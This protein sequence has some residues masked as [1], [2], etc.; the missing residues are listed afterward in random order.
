MRQVET[1]NRNIP[2]H[3]CSSSVRLFTSSSS[4]YYANEPLGQEQIEKKLEE[5]LEKQKQLRD[6]FVQ[7]EQIDATPKEKEEEKKIQGR[8]AKIWAKIKHEV[9][10]YVTGAKLLAANVGI[11]KDLIKK[12]LHGGS[13]TRREK[14]LLRRTTLDIFRVFPFML[15]FII[16]FLEFA[17]P[18]F[19]KMFPQMLPSTFETSLQRE[20]NMKRQLK[21]KLE[22]AKF[23]Q[24]SVHSF[25]PQVNSDEKS[26][27][28]KS[29]DDA[30]QVQQ[31]LA[32]VHSGEELL[33]NEILQLSSLF[34]DEFTLDNLERDQLKAVCKFLNV[35]SFGTTG[36]L[37]Y[38]LRTRFNE[39]KEDD[40]LIDNEG[41]DAL[42][43]EELQAACQ[44]RGMR[45]I[46]VSA[47]VLRRQLQQWLDLSLREKLPTS[48]L[49]L[50][51]ALNITADP[52]QVRPVSTKDSTIADL[53]KLLTALPADV[54]D[55]ALVDYAGDSDQSSEAKLAFL[56]RAREQLQDSDSEDKA[57]AVAAGVID[58]GQREQVL[59][60]L[61]A[62]LSTMA[63]RSAVDLERAELE[64]LKIE[65]DSAPDS[66]FQHTL[67]GWLDNIEDQL[68]KVD[69]SI[70]ENLHLL[71]RDGD[72]I[73][74]QGELTIGLKY[75]KQKLP[76]DEYEYLIQRIDSD[77]DSMISVTDIQQIAQDFQNQ[78]EKSGVELYEHSD[79]SKKQSTNE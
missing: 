66:S 64:E 2:S 63:S 35:Q 49:V 43:F 9:L 41:V 70:G 56:K 37:K 71:D 77:H 55:E 5:K 39:L 24:E 58:P 25:V 18:L 16:P 6:E 48:L 27:D 60:E 38:K 68:Q 7:Q 59:S 72:G 20:E 40:K 36:F 28:D 30:Q 10:H 1:F 13:L 78:K 53:Q 65:A 69:S 51:R 8:M 22:V 76:P 32:R 67:E 33:P 34:R 31:I 75:L 26:N 73:I 23:L 21:V 15:F 29:S 62:T 45:S 54:F 74:S 3:F 57:T 61:T 4:T 19:L 47:G 79:S 17:L 12:L 44:S 42:D 52:R 14:R 11:C 50:S 46:N